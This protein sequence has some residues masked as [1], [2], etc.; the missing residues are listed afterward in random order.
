MTLYFFKHVH[1]LC[2]PW[3]FLLGYLFWEGGIQL[4]VLDVVLRL[5]TW[6]LLHF[7]SLFSF[8]FPPTCLLAL[9]TKARIEYSSLRDFGFLG[10]WVVIGLFLYEDF[11]KMIFWLVL[12]LDRVIISWRILVSFRGFY[13]YYIFEVWNIWVCIILLLPYDTFLMQMARPHCDTPLV[14]VKS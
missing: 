7:S 14:Q 11:R 4:V 13:E 5:A 3:E 10:T 1:C 6:K 8:L 2:R 12:K 9:L